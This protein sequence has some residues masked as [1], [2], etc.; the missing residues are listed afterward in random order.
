MIGHL[1]R[2]VWNRKRQNLLLVVEIFLSFVVLF[3]ITFF[4]AYN[5]YNWR[6]PLGF[7][8]DRR[9]TVALGYPQAGGAA[10]LE[11]DANEEQTRLRTTATETLGRVLAAI[12]DFAA[13]EKRTF[14]FP[15]IPYDRGGWSTG[16]QAPNGTA[17]HF[18]FVHA[19]SDE[20]PDVM[21]TRL[22]AGRWFSRA[23]DGAATRPV[24]VNAR[25]AGELFGES[26]PLNRELPPVGNG[27]TTP[28][29]IIGVFEEYRHEGE[30]RSPGNVL[31]MRL[32]TP[33]T[34]PNLITVRL[35]AGTPAS[36]EET[37]ARTLAQVAPDWTFDIRS[38]EMRRQDTLRQAIAPFAIVVILAM[39]LL[40][41]VALGITGVV[42]QSVTVRIQEFGLRRAKGAT[43]GAI[44]RQVI[45]ELLLLASI[46]LVPVILLAQ[47][48]P[49]A[50]HRGGF[51]NL[52]PP[53]VWIASLA[54]SV[55]VIYLLTLLCAWYPSRLATRTQP[56]DALHH[57]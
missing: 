6:Q 8:I 2:L 35:R 11:G 16:V 42:W 47:V 14:S 21:G 10:P 56:A 25:L 7:S 19:V 50:T 31:L 15:S 26:S 55:I 4:A 23:D 54:V 39:F 17:V 38:L 51:G 45:T 18:V 52:A 30:L 5:Y 36:F 40:L 29:R 9:W 27:F 12:D 32:T 44:R 33:E 24:V 53:A 46:A 20:F 13:I 49:L 28:L 48:P 43:A 1:L 22:L 57:E 41:M 34:M 3:A 37:L